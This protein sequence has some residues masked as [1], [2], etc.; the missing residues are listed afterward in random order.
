MNRYFSEIDHSDDGYSHEKFQKSY[1]GWIRKNPEIH[2]SHHFCDFPSKMTIWAQKWKFCNFSELSFL[3]LNTIK[4]WKIRSASSTCFLGCDNSDR[5]AQLNR[6]YREAASKLQ[7]EEEWVI[8][9]YSWLISHEIFMTENRL[10]L[11]SFNLA[12]I[13]ILHYFLYNKFYFFMFYFFNV[14]IISIQVCCHG[15]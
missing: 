13:T 1:R 7:K 10:P 15:N 11:I 2:P 14:P 8:L 5:Q 9:D 3:K 4:N 6:I 12:L